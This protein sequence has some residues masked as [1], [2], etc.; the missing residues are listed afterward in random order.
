MHQGVRAKKL[1]EKLTSSVPNRAANHRVLLSNIFSSVFIKT[2]TIATDSAIASSNSL[3]LKHCSQKQAGYAIMAIGLGYRLRG[4]PKTPRY[5]WPI[6]SANN[7]IH[8]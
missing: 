2:T 5:T 7:N 8:K 1:R 4:F 3:W 6:L